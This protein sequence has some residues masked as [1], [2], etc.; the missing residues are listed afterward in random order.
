MGGSGAALVR[1][2]PQETDERGREG[3]FAVAA[4]LAQP[5][6][7]PGRVE[8]ADPQVQGALAAGAGFEVEADQQQVEVGVVAGG[9]DSADELGQLGVAQ[10]PP[11]APDPPRLGERGSRVDGHQTGVHCAGGQGPQRSDTGLL[12]RAARGTG[13]VPLGPSCRLHYDG[14]EVD[15]GDLGQGPVAQQL[16]R[17]RPRRPVGPRGRLGEGRRHRG[18]V[19]R[20]ARH[21]RSGPNV[22]VPRLP[23]P[24]PSALASTRTSVARCPRSPLLPHHQLTHT[25]QHPDRRDDHQ[26]RVHPSTDQ[27]RVAAP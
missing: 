4:F 10:R 19:L 5:D 14:P 22:T 12:A 7:G 6:R 9:P 1:M 15:D 13:S 20:Q 23:T 24:T 21:R 17:Q 16:D 3:L 2:T 27:H 11:P 26:G 8:V 18:H 25:I